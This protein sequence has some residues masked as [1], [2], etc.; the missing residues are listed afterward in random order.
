M[1]GVAEPHRAA[2]ISAGSPL[3]RLVALA[4]LLPHGVPLSCPAALHR[5]RVNGAHANHFDHLS[6]R[7]IGADR[8]APRLFRRRRRDSVPARRRMD[9]LLSDL[10]DSSGGDLGDGDRL[11]G[12]RAGSATLGVS[13]GASDPRCG[14]RSAAIFPDGR[15]RSRSARRD[16]RRRAGHDR[17]GE[18]DGRPHP[19]VPCQARLY[20]ARTDFAR[21]SPPRYAGRIPGHDRLDYDRPLRRR[22][23]SCPAPWL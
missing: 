18:H 14:L 9:R 20:G 16:A 19:R 2:G 23:R 12:P 11:A 4:P 22:I 17:R 13:V 7:R 6:N 5:P 8:R 1:R 10:S 15:L 3:T 21:P